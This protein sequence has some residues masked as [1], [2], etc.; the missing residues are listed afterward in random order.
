MASRR[1]FI[2]KSELALFKNLRRVGLRALVIEEDDDLIGAGISE[3]GNEILLSTKFG[4]AC[5]FDQD[6]DQIRPM[7]RTARGVTGMRFKI[8]GDSVVSLE[9]IREHLYE[10]PAE[11]EEGEEVEVEVDVDE[12]M[13][14][15]GSGPEVL[16]VT[17]GG[18]GK[19]SYVSTYRKTKRGAKGVVN[20][21]LREG[22]TV[23]SV[24][25]ITEADEILLTTERGQLVRIPAHE[26]RRV[27]RASYGVRIMNLNSGDRITGVAKLVEVDVPKSPATEEG[28]AESSETPAEVP[29]AETP[30]TEPAEDGANPPAGE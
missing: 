23:L 21:K 30:A 27:G 13:P 25:Q 12:E 19:R 28:G 11:D 15:V 1:G 2:K 7:G 24:V 6:D 4:M 3:N 17:D 5:L 8:E 29:V 20:I 22:E 9:I 16:V 26:I 14:V 10:E 18:M